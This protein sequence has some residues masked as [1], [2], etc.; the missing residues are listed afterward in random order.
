M[1]RLATAA[2]LKRRTDDLRGRREE[3]GGC[4]PDLGDPGHPLLRTA[5]FGSGVCS[6]C[7][8][9]AVSPAHSVGAVV[10][11]MAEDHWP[12]ERLLLLLFSLGRMARLDLVFITLGNAA[13]LAPKFLACSSSGVYLGIETE[14]VIVWDACRAVGA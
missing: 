8:V 5:P 1:S 2:A 11:A 13:R 12:I 3:A 9:G 6:L 10:A 4:V 7:S 14:G